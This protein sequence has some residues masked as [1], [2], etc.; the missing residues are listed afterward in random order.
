MR[1]GRKSRVVR[2]D[3]AGLRRLVRGILREAATKPD[4]T[5]LMEKIENFVDQHNEADKDPMDHDLHLDNVLH[6][7]GVAIEDELGKLTRWQVHRVR[8]HGSGTRDLKVADLMQK[9]SP[10]SKLIMVSHGQDDMITEPLIDCLE[11]YGL[12][13]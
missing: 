12:K 11:S 2:L 3:E 9:G 6:N 1:N 4:L 5:R 10:R 7:N 8:C 13:T